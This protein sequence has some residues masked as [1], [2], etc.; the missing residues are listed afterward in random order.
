[1]ASQDPNIQ[2]QIEW[3]TPSRPPRRGFMSRILP[4]P[5]PKTFSQAP[6]Q[7]TDDEALAKEAAGLGPSATHTT[8]FDTI[9]A[10]PVTR[11]R[12]ATRPLRRRLDALLP[13]HRTNIGGR[14]FS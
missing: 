10:E 3:E 14:L 1:M 13:P 12:R 11:G 4:T 6:S 9:P 7:T 8:T 5:P 2:P